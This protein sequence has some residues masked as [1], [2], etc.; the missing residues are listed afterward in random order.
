[1]RLLDDNPSLGS[2]ELSNYG[3]ALL[4]PHLITILEYAHARSVAIT[5]E[6][7]VNLN[8]CKDEL[9]EALV[10]Y[11]VRTVTC[12]IDG[13]SRKTYR[14]YR[15][16]GDFDTV[17]GNVERIN[18]FKRV[19]RSEFPRLLWQFVVFGHNEEEIPIAREMAAALGM[20]FVTK[21]SWDDKVSPVNDRGYV[22]AQTGEPATTR[23]EYE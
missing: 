13:A 15:V 8:N 4:N 6:N 3:E 12:S 21:I 5:L 2:V 14:V 23:P 18:H 7:G 9:L 19:Y 22:A 20:K 10:K 11:R 1:K 17:I 16:R